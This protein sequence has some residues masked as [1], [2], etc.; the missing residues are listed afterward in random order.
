MAYS[1]AEIDAVVAALNAGTITPAQLEQQ[2]GM[3]AAEI[4]ANLDAVNAAS[5]YTPEPVYTPQNAL[6]PQVPYDGYFD[7]STPIGGY[8][9]PNLDGMMP[10]YGGGYEPD[11]LGNT[12]SVYTGGGGTGAPYVPVGIPDDTEGVGAGADILNAQINDAIYQIQNSGM[13]G[14]EQVK[15]TADFMRNAGIS[16]HA[17]AQVLGVPVDQI[18]IAL[19]SGGYDISGNTTQ[20]EQPPTNSE[21]PTDTGQGNTDMPTYTDTEIQDVIARVNSGELT[22]EDLVSMYPDAGLSADEIQANIDAYNAPSANDGGGTTSPP[23][24]GTT[25]PPPIGGANSGGIPANTTSSNTHT[26]TNQVLPPAYLQPLLNE[27]VNYGRGALGALGNTLNQPNALI[28]PFNDVQL[29]S[30]DQAAAFARDP[31]G[32]LA[33]SQNVLREI[34]D[35]S[36]IEALFGRGQNLMESGAGRQELGRFANTDA[37]NQIGMNALQGTAAGNNLYGG[38]GFDEAVAASMRAAQPMIAS[39]FSNAGSGGLKSGL[40]QIGMQQAASDAFAQQYGQE[41]G[42][43]LNAANS[44]NSMALANRGMQTDAAGRLL[45]ADM[46]AGNTQIQAAD[47]DRSRQMQAAQQLPQYGLMGSDI[48]GSI[49]AQ[50]QNQDTAQRQ[51]GVDQYQK[52]MEYSFGQFNPA[53]LM[54][55]A[56]SQPVYQNRGSGLLGGALTGANMGAQVG[57]LFGG[58]GDKIGAGIGGIAGGLLGGGYF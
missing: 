7:S 42:N 49:G 4:Q 46:Q 32:D 39:T 14:P 50:Q 51:A 27:S 2:Y 20:G 57:G 25:T 8:E 24:G 43:Q 1:Q 17:V 48:L 44:L 18:E 35:S 58:S 28:S 23:P 41:R 52:L 34:S 37:Q 13:T 53:S 56:Q 9:Q 10:G 55:Q 33:Q 11:T 36:D 45:G 5:G 38:A 21:Q 31:S 16:G 3:P 12:G 54:G 29:E 40:A 6:G 26:I 19:A 30:M 22:A 15:A 47:A